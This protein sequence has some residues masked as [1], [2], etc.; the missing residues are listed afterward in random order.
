MGA[1]EVPQ[2]VRVVGEVRGHP[3]EDD[4]EA[5]PV[6]RVDEVSEIIR[7]A[8]PRGGCEIAH[9]LVA[10]APVERMLGD[11]HQLDVG[12][13]RVLEVSD[14]LVGELAVGE[15]LAAVPPLFHEPRCTSYTA[16]GW[17]RPC[18]SARLASH[19]SSCH[20]NFETSQTTDAVLGR[21]S[22]AKP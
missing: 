18:R 8:E 7:R 1:V 21:N 11:R 22:A 20:V 3:V 13:L 9:R 6:Q 5:V 19:S 4:A 14:Q 15:E 17:S 10:P 2:A 16:I 12:E